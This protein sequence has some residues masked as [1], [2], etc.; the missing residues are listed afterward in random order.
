MLSG[1]ISSCS[2]PAAR[3]S[4][5]ASSRRTSRRHRGL[6]GARRS[7]PRRQALGPESAAAAS[8]S[9]VER[10]LQPAAPLAQGAAHVPE[11]MDRA[12]EAELE[13]G[14]RALA[15]ED[16][17][18]PEVVVVALDD[19]EGGLGT[20]S[21]EASVGASRRARERTRDVDSRRP[22]PPPASTS[23]SAARW[24]TISSILKRPSPAGCRRLAVDEHLER[25]HR[26][27]RRSPRPPRPRS[28]RERPTPARRGALRRADQVVAP[29]DRRADRA[30]P[31]G[32]VTRASRQGVEATAKPLEQRRRARAA[33]S[34]RRP[35][36][37]R[38]AGRRRRRRSRR[39]PPRSRVVSLERPAG[40]PAPAP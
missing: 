39:R 15:R 36:R 37:A 14:E 35:A 9:H 22:L 31:L 34:G 12:R 7:R 17:R 26:R 19:R 1:P 4:S 21:A 13:L 30:L 10:L 25:L 2:S 3:R 8:R 20:G 27:R 11:P 33:S 40:P 16:E 29:V 38:A 23:R 24:R 5:R 28:R 18:G 32:D 6:P